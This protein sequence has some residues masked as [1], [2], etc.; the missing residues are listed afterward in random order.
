MQSGGR[1]VMIEPVR[2]AVTRALIPGIESA[3][4]YQFADP[5]DACLISISPEET[6]NNNYQGQPTMITALLEEVTAVSAP[7]P[8]SFSRAGAAAPAMTLRDGNVAMVLSRSGQGEIV[9][10]SSNLFI[11]ASLASNDNAR[12][13]LNLASGSRRVV[14]DEYHLGYRQSGGSI[15]A[16]PVQWRWALLGL[17]LAIVSYA[18]AKAP[19]RSATAEEPPILPRTRG[20]F[21]DALAL[22]LERA[23][24]SQTAV[25]ILQDDLRTRLR[26]RL[27][28]GGWITDQQIVAASPGLGLDPAAVSSALRP[29]PAEDQALVERAREI[30]KLRREL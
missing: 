20:E 3:N 27:L 8:M 17:L 22:S 12:L 30:T 15:L 26:R 1:L 7:S 28:M 11:N 13:A 4:A 29:I 14:F 6:P 16:L 18:W 2:G 19:R 21:I 23:G 24:G 9:V 5:D 10:L 25:R